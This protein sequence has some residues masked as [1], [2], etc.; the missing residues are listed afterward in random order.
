[1]TLIGA[2]MRK[3]TNRLGLA[4]LALLAI[5]A[6]L[7]AVSRALYPTEAQRDALAVMQLPAPPEGENAFAALWTLDRA[8][9][10]KAMQQVIETD[11]AR[12]AGLPQFPDRDNAGAFEFDSAAE[13]YP[14]LA[15]SP[16]DRDLF[17]NHE[18]DDCLDKVAA[19]IPT[20]RALVERNREL[21]DRIDALADYDYVRQQLPWN[22]SV[23][24]LAPGRAGLSSTRTRC[25]F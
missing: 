16:E 9:P 21:L 7:W 20:Y 13:Q 15:P 8:V 4:V 22:M 19:D 17:C 5:M 11:A 14:D 12:I 24:I 18:R 1:M 25:G 2:T 6:V 23:S 10:P 3:W